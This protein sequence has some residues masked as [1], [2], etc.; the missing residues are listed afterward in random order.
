[1]VYLIFSSG[2]LGLC[3]QQLLLIRFFKKQIQ[4]FSNRR[5]LANGIS[6]DSWAVQSTSMMYFGSKG[7]A[8]FFANANNIPGEIYLGRL[9]ISVI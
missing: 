1:M 2:Y 9:D 8:Y 4:A 5:F 6:A 3:Y 7:I